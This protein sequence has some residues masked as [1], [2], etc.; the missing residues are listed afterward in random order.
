MMNRNLSICVFFC[1][2]YVALAAPEERHRLYT[3]P[4]PASTGG[5]KAMIV[6]PSG[7]IEAVFACP[8]DEPKLVYQGVVTGSMSQEFLF[9]NL[10]MRKYDL[11]VVYSKTLYEGFQLERNGDT[12]TDLDRKKIKYTIDKAEPYFTKKIVYRVE[13]TTGRGNEARVIASYLRDTASANSSQ[14]GGKPFRRTFKLVILKD[15]GPGWQ[16]ERAR[17]LYPIWTTKDKVIA[18]HQYSKA[19]SNIRV[20]ST[21]NDLG[22]I[23]LN[24]K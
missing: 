20:T 16:V 17:D 18:S 5:I 24:S 23:N 12:L 1:A 19:L 21:I 14:G 9:E 15:V 10:P 13:G 2:V 4:D 3:K 7:P 8:P 22:N 11:M 6:S